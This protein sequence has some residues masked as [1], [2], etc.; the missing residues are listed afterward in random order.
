MSNNSEL[1]TFRDYWG[2][3]ESGYGYFSNLYGPIE[4]PG[5]TWSSGNMFE[6]GLTLPNFNMDDAVFEDRGCWHWGQPA[7]LRMADSP[8]AEAF[9]SIF[10]S[11]VIRRLQAVEQLTLPPEYSTIPN[12]GAFSTAEHCMGCMLFARQFSLQEGVSEE[13]AVQAEMI[14]L[15]HDDGKGFGGHKWDWL[16]QSVGGPENKHDEDLYKYLE[17]HGIIDILHR[18]NIDPQ[19]VI[20]P[21]LNSWADCPSP[22]L[23]VDR[24]D[25]GLR[26]MNRWNTAIRSAAFS[27]RDFTRTP[28]GMMAM[29]DQQRARLFSEGYLS[30]S[31]ENWSEPTHRFIEAIDM[32]RLKLFYGQGGAPRSWVFKASFD[33][34]EALVP[35][36]EISPF[37]LMYVTDPAQALAMQTPNLGVQ[38][39]DTIMKDVSRYHRQYVWPGRSDRI[40]NYMQQF[41]ESTYSD[42]LAGNF[43]PLESTAFDSFREE[44]PPYLPLGFTIIDAE[45]EAAQDTPIGTVDFALRPFKVRQ[46]DPLVEMPGGL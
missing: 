24:V 1:P 2:A 20:N 23:C 26:E 18:N 44:Y 40:L 34:G 7:E 8:Y 21:N 27:V 25:Y 17:V 39:L 19:T 9:T 13:E 29:K 41:G 42:V 16:Q 22:D 33:D 32:L 38:V 6:P 3:E 15:L 31:E 37:D 46:I 14:G 35:L 36:H 4:L 10:F 43:E 5:S 30:L 12:T 28:E 11:G 45:S